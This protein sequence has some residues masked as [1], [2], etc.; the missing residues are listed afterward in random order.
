MNDDNINIT[1]KRILFIFAQ[2]IFLDFF[3]KRKINGRLGKG[4]QTNMY[5]L[6]KRKI[7]IILCYNCG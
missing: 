7:S 5:N 4:S 6:N 2:N 1:N 3:K